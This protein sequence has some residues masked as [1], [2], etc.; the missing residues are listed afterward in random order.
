MRRGLMGR[1]PVGFARCPCYVG[2]PVSLC[3]CACVCV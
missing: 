3:A 2:T 1:A